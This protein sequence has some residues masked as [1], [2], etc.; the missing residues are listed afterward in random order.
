M[1]VYSIADHIISPLG[2]GTDQNFLA[3]K[4]AQSGLREVD[5]DELFPEPFYG[6]TIPKNQ[7]LEQFDFEDPDKFSFLE[8][9]FIL[10]I[11][12]VLQAVPGLHE[13]RLLLIISTTKGNIDL[14]KKDSRGLTG[15]RIQLAEM[16]KVVNHYFSIP[17]APIVVSNACIS[18]VSA[19][20]TASKLIR[21]GMYDHVLV[22][23]GDI[24]SEFTLSGFHCLKAMSEEACRPYDQARKGINLGE[25]C[26]T[27]LLSNDTALCSDKQALSVISGGGQSNDANHISGPSRTGKGLKIAIKQA[28]RTAGAGTAL[29]P[30]EIGYI[31]AH[32]TA[33]PFNDEMEAIAFHDLGLKDVPL[34][35]L[36]AYFGHTLGAAGVIESIM[37]I[38]QM[39]HNLL[40][41]SLGYE[42]HGVSMDMNVL[43]ENKEVSELQYIMKTVSGF[44]GCNAA[45]IMEKV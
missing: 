6:A 42:Q 2:F 39:N 34:N 19:M 9:L 29:P 41:K 43:K 23:G 12:S 14:L 3:L 32:G 7:L 37:A 36:K 10:S 21:M 8:K 28:L 11:R 40:F 30:E 1:R 26:G 22:S 45:V 31:N 5:A 16:A 13:K 15:E 25:S 18:G 33:T 24:L 44:G 27:V 38:R 4:K 20:L 17:H 35:S